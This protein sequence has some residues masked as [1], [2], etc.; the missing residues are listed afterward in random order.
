MI[1]VRVTMR[2]QI[3]NT[4]I[5]NRPFH[6]PVHAASTMVGQIA[7]QGGQVTIFTSENVKEQAS[8]WQVFLNK[9][10]K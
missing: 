9:R 10:Y 2:R 1:N 3:L 4:N 5:S 8:I 6:K 7:L